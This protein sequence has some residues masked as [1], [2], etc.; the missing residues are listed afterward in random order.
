MKS[1]VIHGFGDG[2][3]DLG[4]PTANL[5]QEDC[6]GPMDFDTI[7]CGIYW[8]FAHIGNKETR[9]QFLLVTILHMEM[10]SRLWN[11]ISLLH[12]VMKEDICRPVERQ[13]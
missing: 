13:S 6:E 11:H 10:L 4:I 1:K 7:P 3:T 2:S 5:L 8:G 9:H 12:L